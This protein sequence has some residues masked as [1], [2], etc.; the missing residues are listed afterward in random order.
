MNE[1]EKSQGFTLKDKSV[2][3]V[4]CGGLGCNV[5]IHL[6]GEGT[7]RI[8]LCDF[9]EISMSNLNR[10][11]LYTEADIGKSK[12]L[13][14]AERLRAYN[15]DISVSYQEKK[16]CR[17]EDMLFA[18]NCDMVI[19]AVDNSEARKA[20]QQFCEEYSIPLV[21]GGIDGFYGVCYLYI[22]G[23]SPCP[24]CAGLNETSQVGHNISSTTGIIGSF[25]AAVAVK[26]LLTDDKGL[27]GMLTVYDES[28]FA[29]LEILPSEECN[30]CKTL[31]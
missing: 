10:Q 30:K 31:K 20:V 27:S 11:F 6:A 3:I 26:Y 4:G 28:R 16:I 19:L 25:Q 1:K 5:A 2:C 9:D 15:R 7:G 23:F 29:A 24:D 18:E 14:M 17:P 13:V 12:C 22:P 8:T 21:C